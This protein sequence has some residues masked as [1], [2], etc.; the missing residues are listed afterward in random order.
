MIRRLACVLP[1]V[2]LALMPL[3]RHAAAATPQLVRGA[4]ES[5]APG[6]MV[7]A[8]RT[9]VR[10]DVELIDPLTV[11]I[12][13]PLE[14]TAIAVGRNIGV[15]ATQAQDGSLQAVQLLVLGDGLPT[16]KDGGVRPD[17]RP[18]IPWDMQP[19]SIMVAGRL[20]GRQERDGVQQLT[21]SNRDGTK[22]I[23]VPPKT[24]VAA[25]LPAAR[26]DLKA[27]AIVFLTGLAGPDGTVAASRVIVSTGGSNP[28]M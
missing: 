6:G 20:T 25:V 18:D 19:G 16:A 13:R 24:P 8:D 17:V 2:A 10:V 22:V 12:A 14:Q 1:V 27:G 7:V 26:S 23:F 21:V 3:P 11:L 4:I 5:V 15:V 28:P 9:G